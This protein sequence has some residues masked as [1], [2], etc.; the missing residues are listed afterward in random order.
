MTTEQG[1]APTKIGL[2]TILVIVPF[3]HLILASTYLWA[4]CFGFGAGVG[5][6]VSVTD[7]YAVSIGNLAPLY[8][9]GVLFAIY[10]G[11]D[12]IARWLT[13]GAARRS[14]EKPKGVVW[15]KGRLTRALRFILVI[16][17]CATVAVSYLTG[18]GIDVVMTAL[19]AAVLLTFS[20][21][22]GKARPHLEVTLA[23]VVTVAVGGTAVAGMNEGQRH[24]H[25]GYE[26]FATSYGRC[27]DYVVLR[28]LSSRLLVVS[29]EGTH[30]LVDQECTPRIT[31][32]IPT[33]LIDPETLPSPLN[34]TFSP[35]PSGS[36]D[37]TDPES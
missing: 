11:R 29:P 10:V 20:E 2:A 15:P 21:W 5:T 13:E 19:Y 30:S 3:G 4:Y 18:E 37:G 6:Y 33:A 34:W 31:F 28:Q 8:A 35:T 12:H 7:V 14:L 27:G 32:A 16:T 17:V 24:R 25:G 9:M 23:L 1:R 26:A 36:E 22:F